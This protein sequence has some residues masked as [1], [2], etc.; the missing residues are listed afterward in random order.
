MVA[1]VRIHQTGGPEV[2]TYE[3]VEV[4][5]PGAGQ[6][7]VRQQAIGI[8]Y[9]DTYFRTGL[10]PAPGGFRSSLAAKGRAM[11]RRWALA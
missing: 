5:A 2:L 10:Y 1:A 6:I 4:P 7:R 11:S 3:E 9:I 8:N